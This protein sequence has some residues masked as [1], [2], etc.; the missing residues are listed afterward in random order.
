MKLI[1][2]IPCFNEAES[3]GVTLA[4]LPRSVAGFKDVEWLVV[5]DGS[6]DDTCAAA[7]AGGVDHLVRM[8]G[9]QGLARAF[10]AGLDACLAKGADVIVNTDADNQY[11]AADIPAL[12]APILAGSADIVVGARPIADITHFSP[13]KKVLQRV[14][15]WAVRLVSRADVRD[16]PSGF[17]A[18]SRTAAKRLHVFGEYTYTI[19]TVI[20]A[21]QKGMR[22]VSVP[23]RVNGELRPS[24]LIK[25]IPQ[26]VWRS[27]STIT[28]I[29]I[30][31]RP[32]R[33][34][35][36]LAAGVFGAG[37]LL[38]LRY[39]YLVGQGEGAGHVQSVV[40]AAMLLGSGTFMFLIGIVAD[41]IATNRKLIE[42][43]EWRLR[44]VEELVSRTV[45]PDRAPF[46]AP[47]ASSRPRPVRHRE[48]A[49]T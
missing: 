3:I 42:E 28:R 44:H 30:L 35:T 10:T 7:L 16:A 45:E 1:I 12:V 11:C 9:H 49:A 27:L 22:V 46:P 48:D 36:Y 37:L 26:Y 29:F 14:G 38:S 13:V 20:Q 39:I 34:F 6:G 21:G 47:L 32:L 17:R 8:Q 15:S 18:I 2:Q 33:F 23:V 40:V 4:D 24:R 31:Y 25:S 19:E 5:D 41:L 43:V